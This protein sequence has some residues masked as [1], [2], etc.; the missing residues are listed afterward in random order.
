MS[1]TTDTTIIGMG[2]SAFAT[3]THD[4][5]V[6]FDRVRD[7]FDFSVGYGQL[8]ATYN[9]QQIEVPNRHALI[10]QDTAE[11]L[12]VVSKKYRIHPF[13][14][15]LIDN[16]QTLTD[17]GDADLQILGAGLLQRGAVGWL[18]VQAPTMQIAGDD[19]APTITLASSHNGTLATSYRVGLFRFSCS[20]QIGALRSSRGQRIYKLRHTLNSTVQFGQAREAL[21]LLFTEA[22]QFATDVRELIDTEVTNAQFAAMIRQL[23]PQ[24]TGADVTP[25]AATRWETRWDSLMR[26]W[27]EDERVA[28]YRGT[29]WGAVQ[30]FSTHRQWERPFRA[31]GADGRTTRLGRNMTDYL[32]GRLGEDDARAMEVVRHVAAV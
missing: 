7:L 3:E 13:S 18:Q 27:N 17:S 2:G 5:P 28:P 14:E 31:N 26:L 15:V 30:A 23:D 10:R 4:G 9:D 1:N 32:S 21:G 11:V 25:T 8:H 24:P 16:L 19:L 29:A 6:P 20:N 22:E 12:N